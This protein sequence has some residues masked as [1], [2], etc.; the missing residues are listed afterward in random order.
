MKILITGA[1]GNIGSMLLDEL[2]PRGHEVTAFDL[3]N[4]ANQ[5]VQRRYR[6]KIKTAWGDITDKESMREVSAFKA[7]YSQQHSVQTYRISRFEI[8]RFLSF[9]E[10]RQGFAVMSEERMYSLPHSAH[11]TISSKMNSLNE[12]VSGLSTALVVRDARILSPLHRGPTGGEPR[13]LS[14]G[15]LSE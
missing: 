9:D 6:R 8:S 12:E 1:F 15:P 10:R 7:M 14:P 2:I 13:S 3:K 11:F 4:D 5:K